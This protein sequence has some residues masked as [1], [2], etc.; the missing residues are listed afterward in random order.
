[1]KCQIA[2]VLSALLAVSTAQAQES[3]EYQLAQ[4]V[5]PKAVHSQAAATAHRVP[6]HLSAK[7]GRAESSAAEGLR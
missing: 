1:M 4:P 2:S 6:R 3:S 7:A 5:K